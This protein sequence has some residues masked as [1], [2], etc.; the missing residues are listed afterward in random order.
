MITKQDLLDLREVMQDDLMCVMDDMGARVPG[1]V[2][3]TLTAGEVDELV[4]RLC[5]VVVDRVEP[6]LEKVEG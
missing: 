1:C 3:V 4:T 5:Q 2:A 6:L